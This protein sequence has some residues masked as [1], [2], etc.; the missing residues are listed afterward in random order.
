MDAV[1]QKMTEL[2]ALIS[3]GP[4]TGEILLSLLG[5]LGLSLVMWLTYRRANK[6]EGYQPHF[7]V[8]LISLAL[9]STIL[10]DLIQS[11]LALSL[12]MLGS[13]SIVRF[14]TNIRDPRDIGFLFWAMAI[15]LAAATQSYGIGLLGSLVVALC[16]VVTADR[17]EREMLLV[18]RGSQTDLDSVGRIVADDCTQ[19]R[20]KAK[21]IMADSFELVYEVRLPMQRSNPMIGRLFD[22]RGIDTVN[23]LAAEKAM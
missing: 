15:G 22:L 3:A 2:L 10:M 14:R 5:A 16:M 4:T 8:T 20:V 6:K 12:G 9:L 19:S 13:L 1:N 11:N 23:L 18:V 7:A 21:N 17:E